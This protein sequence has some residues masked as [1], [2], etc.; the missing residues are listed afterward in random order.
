MPMMSIK[1]LMRAAKAASVELRISGADIL[2]DGIERLSEKDGDALER[3]R[4]PYSNP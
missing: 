1:K 3:L 2:V 4:V